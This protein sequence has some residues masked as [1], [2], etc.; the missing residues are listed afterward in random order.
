MGQTEQQL[1]TGKV[2]IVGYRW[3]ICLF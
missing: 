3:T 2:G 1:K